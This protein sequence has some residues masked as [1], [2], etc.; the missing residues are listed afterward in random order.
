MVLQRVL[1]AKVEIDD[2]VVGAIG[3]GLL[4]LVAFASEDGAPEIRWMVDKLVHLRVFNDDA[5]RMNRDL[6]AVDGAMLVVS[7]FTLYGNATH[8]R[9]PDFLAAAPADVARQRYDE[10]VAELRRTGLVVETGEFG[11]DMRVSLVND[12]PV[13]LIVE[14]DRD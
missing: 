5:G 9:R 1:D 10:F 14:R 8:G 7:Q 6:R 13:T 3:R 12:G 2:H 11:A 4:L